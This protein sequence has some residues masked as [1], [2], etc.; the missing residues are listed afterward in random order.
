MEIL[1]LGLILWIFVHLVPAMTPKLKKILVLR[2]GANNF[3]LLFTIL[4]VSSVSLIVYGWRNSETSI[5]YI[6]PDF[7]YP[8]STAILLLSYLL[9]ASAIFPNRFLS[10]IRHPQ[11]MF[12]IA[13]AVA[14]LLVNGDIRSITLFSGM[15]A[16]AI[17][18]IAFINK[19]DGVRVKKAAP[20]L[21]ITIKS[22]VL[23]LVLFFATVFGHQFLSGVA[24]Y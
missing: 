8:I 17:M 11:L 19:R 14:H 21:T 23:G 22:F 1:V 5:L 9:F 7:V 13:W 6:L 18:E 15:G 4:I 2:M 10:F 3:K 12:I 16:W 20:T 24:L